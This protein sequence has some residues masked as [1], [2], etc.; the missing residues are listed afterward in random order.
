[1]TTKKKLY[2]VSADEDGMQALLWAKAKGINEY[3]KGLLDEPIKTHSD[4]MV[5]M[6]KKIQ[7]LSKVLKTKLDNDNTK[8][9]DEKN[10]KTNKSTKTD[11]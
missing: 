1:M 7:E 11:T 6:Y 10:G 4:S 3:K 9:E 5:W 2:H 8:S